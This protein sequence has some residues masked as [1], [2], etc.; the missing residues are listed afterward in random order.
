MKTTIIVEKRGEGYILDIF[1]DKQTKRGERCGLTPLDVATSV[2]RY[3][4]QQ[5]AT[6]A[7]LV[8]PPE[9]RDLIPKHLHDFEAQE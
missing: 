4:A 9:V 7:S 3:L 8:A 1:S 6:G 5:T 2:S